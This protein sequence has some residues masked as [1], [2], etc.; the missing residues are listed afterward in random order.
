MNEMERVA[1]EHALKH[2]RFDE[3]GD[4]S[5]WG[6]G[7]DREAVDDLAKTITAA[8]A[9]MRGEPV[10]WQPIETAPKDGQMFLFW[11]MGKIGIGHEVTVECNGVLEYRIAI[12]PIK[13]A[14]DGL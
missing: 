2:Y 12:L 11:A 9:A 7:R 10:G 4:L 14:S 3:E 1:R 5:Y 13:E 6:T 8:I